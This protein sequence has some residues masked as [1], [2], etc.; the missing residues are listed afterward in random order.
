MDLHI[1]PE[2]SVPR[3]HLSRDLVWAEKRRG[4][5]Y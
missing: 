2:K 1:Q 5:A 4:F 3:M